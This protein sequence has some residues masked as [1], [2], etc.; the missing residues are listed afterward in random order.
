[1]CIR[2]RNE[3]IG[4]AETSRVPLAIFVV[5]MAGLVYSVL[6]AAI[7][8][9]RDQGTPMPGILFVSGTVGVV[10]L[11]VI[12]LVRPGW[13]VLLATSSRDLNYM[14]LAGIFNALAFAALVSAMHLSGLVYINALNASQ[15]A[16]A[17]IA[18]VMFF[19]EALTFPLILGVTLTGIGLLLMKSTRSTDD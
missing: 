3:S 15:T 16:M 10:V 1:M 13:D 2:D 4:T 12:C 18:G 6:G 8:W 7:R 14:L 5:C 9:S 19:D 11:G 17:S